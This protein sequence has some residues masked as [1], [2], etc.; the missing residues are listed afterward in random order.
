ME[1]PGKCDL[2]SSDTET[3]Y[4]PKKSQIGLQ[5]LICTQCGFVQSQKL[6][7]NA[8]N[9]SN[10]EIEALSCDSDYSPIRVGKQQMTKLDIKNIEGCNL[11]CI[12]S[13]DFLDM[14]SARGH[15]AAWAL[16]KTFK[17]VTCL[18]PDEYMVETYLGDNRI[19]LQI[20]DYREV[21]LLGQF[22]FIYSCHTLEHFRSPT[23]YLDFVHSHLN[24][25]GY[26]YLN[27]PNL[28]GILQVTALDDFFYDKHRVY[29]DPE[30]LMSILRN[31]GFEMVTSWVDSACIRYLVRKAEKPEK[32]D[33][34]LNYEKNR[35]LILEYTRSLNTSR[36]N[37]PRLVNLLSAQLDPY[38]TK[39]ILGCGRM[40]DAIIS[41]GKL[42]L[43]QFDFIVDNYLG[44]ATKKLYSRNLYTLDNLPAIPGDIQFLVV[45][46]TSNFELG[47]TISKRFPHAKVIYFSEIGN[48]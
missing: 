8:Q 38:S 29:F 43:S 10:F 12:S 41:Y 26:L 36:E 24:A 20:G 34:P 25:N 39:I 46:R 30:T 32:I 1:S 21:E 14:A 16:T 44:L 7:L 37:L 2:C 33:Y 45:A 4:R 6:E 9:S 48:E 23:Q 3:L 15:F 13:F 18:E 5:I 22:D 19:R 17:D 35:K 31:C 42:D 47:A 40:L 28:T 27:V 11:D